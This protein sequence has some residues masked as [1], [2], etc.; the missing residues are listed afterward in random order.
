MIA[1]PSGGAG[2]RCVTCEARL[3]L[4]PGERFLAGAGGAALGPP[5]PLRLRRLLAGRFV[6]ATPPATYT[7]AH[8]CIITLVIYLTRPSAHYTE[9]DRR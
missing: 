8:T 3:K 6:S 4:G 5:L 9:P 1:A 2:A 7:R